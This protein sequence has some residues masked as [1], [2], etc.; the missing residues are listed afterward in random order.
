MNI[1]NAAPT[2]SVP[3][4]SQTPAPPG[5]DLAHLRPSNLIGSCIVGSAGGLTTLA[6]FLAAQPELGYWLLGQFLLAAALVQW[7][8]LLHE[9]GHRTLF[10]SR[11]LNQLTGHVAGYFAVIPFDCW[12][13]VHGMHHR[14][15]GWQ[16]LDMTTATLVPR[17][18]SAV[19]RFILNACWRLWI[20]LFSTLYR[21]NNFWNLPRLCRIFRHRRER[22]RLIRGVL[23]LAGAYAITAVLVGP[24]ELLRLGGLG[25][26]LALIVQ[27]P[28][29]LSQ[30]THVPLRLSH[31]EAVRPFLPR[32]QEV[33][34]RSLRLPRWVSAALLHLD[35]H[36][37]HHMYARVPGYHLRRIP[38]APH[39][40]MGWWQWLRRAKALP[41]AVFLFQN[42]DQ[43][44]W[45]I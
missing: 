19:E 43:T 29:I 8:A 22:R 25:L 3:L 12:K 17:P 39:N 33:Y 36:E 30:H 32:E 5:A 31:G 27:D 35:A 40:E 42:R 38:Y 21:I 20:P 34:T 10:R 18:L 4:A 2:L 15:T 9:A 7:F 24:G 16:D 1:S 41:G 14:W 13:L 11:P 6:V 44:G 26:L 37:L 23:V 45:P 28:L